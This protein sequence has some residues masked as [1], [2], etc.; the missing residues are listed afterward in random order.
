MF[1]FNKGPPDPAFPA[2]LD[3]T[4][5][6]LEPSERIVRASKVLLSNPLCS[7]GDSR[8]SNK[9]QSSSMMAEQ[10]PAMKFKSPRPS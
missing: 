7:G 1:P 8:H 10:K 3:P 6:A 4:S 2:G 5:A 9:E